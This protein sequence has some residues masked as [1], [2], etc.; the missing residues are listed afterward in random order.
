MDCTVP[1]L[2]GVVGTTPAEIRLERAVKGVGALIKDFLGVSV[3]VLLLRLPEA[4]AVFNSD[5]AAPGEGLVAFDRFPANTNGWRNAD[6]GFS[7]RS[8]SHARHFPI[9]STNESSSHL[10]T[11]AR[12]LLPGRLRRPFEFT[13]GRGAPVVSSQIV[14]STRKDSVTTQLTEE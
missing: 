14:S 9:K 11:C 2:L 7:R 3:T 6:W 1:E 12:V 5:L 8:G 13:T 10:R 4:D